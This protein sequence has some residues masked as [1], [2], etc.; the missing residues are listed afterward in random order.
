MLSFPFPAT[1]QILQMC[2]ARIILAV[3]ALIIYWIHDIYYS[4]AYA[5][6]ILLVEKENKKKSQRMCHNHT[7]ALTSSLEYSSF[8]LWFHKF[9]CVKFSVFYSF[10]QAVCDIN[11]K[12]GGKNEH[13]VNTTLYSAQNADILWY[14]ITYWL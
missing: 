1:S 2:R 5:C 9:F 8:S 11:K 14:I 13:I 12:S 7:H 4:W 6:I 10:C 3:D